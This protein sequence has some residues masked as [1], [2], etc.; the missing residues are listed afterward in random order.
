MSEIILLRKL[1]NFENYKN[2]FIVKYL[3]SL[4]PVLVGLNAFCQEEFLSGLFFSS[5][6]VIQDKRT[7]LN[8]T[9]E[10]PF[11]FT[12]GFTLEFDANFREGDGYYGY[13]FRIIGDDNTN[14]DFVSNNAPETSNFWLVLKDTVLFSY[15]WSE[16]PN[17]SFDK[18]LNIK[19]AINTRSSKL[20]ISFN[21]NK[22]EV[23]VPAISNLK[24]FE[25]EFGAS[26]NTNFL[27]TDVAPMSL[28]DIRIFNSSN[29]LLH[30]WKLSKHV[31]NA[32]YDEVGNLE[33]KVENPIWSIDKHVEWKKVKDLKIDNL[34]GIAKDEENA[35]VFLV[36]NKSVYVLST[37]TATI[38]TLAFAGGRPFL[39]LGKQ[40]VYNK[41][42]K[43]LW[44]YSFDSKEISKFSFKDYKWSITPLEDKD[45]P[46]YWHHNFFISPVD[47]SLTTLFGYGFY[48][49]KSIIQY[50]DEKAKTW[51]KIDRSQQVYP[52]YLSGSGLLN[53]T[54]MLVF[55]GY[56]SKTGR[57]ELSPEYYYDL[58]SLNLKNLT[59]KKLW[60]L[61]SLPE[62]FVPVDAL[63]PDQQEGRF[64]TLLYNR[65]NY[66]TYLRLAKFG[67]YN[68][69]Y[70]FY[71]DSIPYNFLD[72]ESWSTLFLDKKNTQ[73]VALTS[74]NSEVSVYSIAFPPLLPINVYQQ[75]PA[76]TS[77]DILLVILVAVLLIGLLLFFFIRY[78]K[79]KVSKYGQSEGDEKT[80]ISPISPTPRKKVNSVYFIGG[81][82]IYDNKGKNISSAF[83][84]TLKQL[85]FYIFLYTNKN[86]KGVTSLKLEEVLWYDKL[87]E[88]ARNNRN[89]NISKLRSVLANVDG[90]ELVNENSFWKIEMEEPVFSDYIEVLQILRKSK[91]SELSE[92]EINQLISLLSVG[93]FLPGL[94]TEWIDK[95]KS[96]FTNELIDEITS[97]F[98]AQNVKG[99]LSL[100]YHLAECILIFEPLNDDAFAMKCKVLYRLGKV[101][102]AKK[103][104][105][106]FCKDYKK[107]LG[108]NYAISFKELVN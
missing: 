28:K 11:K 4:I 1:F 55:G 31:K 18:W 90:I 27:N 71:N 33:A 96:Q 42:T 17:A 41:F 95:F 23:V 63:I 24:K 105:D 64:F 14:I 26:R 72:T 56:G 37:K 20:I 16:I 47:S 49:Y 22:Q 45:E 2:N 69:D 87:G 30:N 21:G 5:H 101:G 77:F 94:Q 50:Y 80:D 10:E 62:P 35:R 66:K 93:E 46:E 32:V 48:T 92:I 39:G 58:Y 75:I 89:V 53:D 86:G 74:H 97:L 34:L 7:T 98:K 82:Q 51:D 60:S 107:A 15:K 99:N 88:S 36:D 19:V 78:R 54:E 70:Q 9:P 67:I 6:E 8:L 59:F 76:K 40:I 103:A 106:S 25:I 57:Q 91:T 81:F 100:L 84:P 12:D 52:R 65:G 108:I 61:E 29:K 3:L 43:E 73:L 79:N 68:N 83:S 13:I 104:Y 44:S 102:R 38:D 85:F